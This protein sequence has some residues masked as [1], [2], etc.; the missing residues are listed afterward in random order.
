MRTILILLALFIISETAF[1][2]FENTSIG[3]R[4]GDPLGITYKKYLPGERALE[5][6]LGSTNVG[7]YSSY[8]S[9]TFRRTSDY[10]NF[11]Y[12]GNS[13]D[14]AIGFQARYLFHKDFSQITPGMDWYYGFGGQVRLMGVTYEYIVVDGPNAGRFGSD[15]RTNIDIGPEAIIGLEYDIPEVPLSAFAEISLFAEIIDNPIRFRMQ[16]AIGIRYNF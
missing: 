15:E 1:A 14:Y 3:L 12:N 11:R 4:L 8:H 5:F 13:V 2:Q 16:G 6:N 9:N 7:F 10:D